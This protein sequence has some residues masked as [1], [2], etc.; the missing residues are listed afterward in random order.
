M[1]RGLHIYM[2]NGRTLLT[3][4]KKNGSKNYAE[5]RTLCQ[6]PSHLGLNLAIRVREQLKQSVVQLRGLV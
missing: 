2:S 1:S 3:L 5:F 6:N 4:E